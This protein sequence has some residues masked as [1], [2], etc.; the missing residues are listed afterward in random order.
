[1]K[2]IFMYIFIVLLVVIAA[3]LGYFI[4]KKSLTEPASVEVGED[5]VTASR[6]PQSLQD[7]EGVASEEEVAVLNAP[8]P[9]ATEEERRSH[10]LLVQKAAKAS[11]YLDITKCSI[12]QPV[13]FEVKD[14]ATFTVKNEDTI[15][16]GIVIDAEH[17]YRI[18]AGET[19]DIVADFGKGPGVYGFGCDSVPHAVGFFLISENE[20]K[21]TPSL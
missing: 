3:G 14:G 15:E 10:F 20:Q 19:K 18:P 9:D 21:I 11:P 7:L 13:V 8:G 2:D 17:T 5:Q 6:P 16:H 4:Y 12:A 1:M